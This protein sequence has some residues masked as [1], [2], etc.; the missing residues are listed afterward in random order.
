MKYKEV[1]NIN[2]GDIV[3]QDLNFHDRV[4]L[5]DGVVITE[6]LLDLLKKKGI[7]GLFIVEQNCSD[8][9]T[10]LDNE[11]TK[12]LKKFFFTSLVEVGSEARYGFALH[13][14]C[15]LNDVEEKFI[16]ILSDEKVYDLIRRLDAHDHGTYLHSFDV[17]VLSAVITRDI[18]LE[19]QMDFLTG[20]LLHDIG[21][22]ETPLSILNKPAK[23]SESEYIQIRNHTK[24]GYKLIQRLS[25]SRLVAQLSKSHHE[26]LD[27][28]GY[29][30]KLTDIRLS[31]ELKILMI[32]DVY[33][34][35]TLN[36][37]Y[38]KAY[39]S[40]KAIDILLK[41]RNKFKTKY[42][43]D[44]MDMLK[45][46]PENSYVYLS[47][48]NI[49]RIIDHRSIPYLP[50]IQINDDLEVRQMPTDLSIRAKSFIQWD[51]LKAN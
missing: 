4:L 12:Q 36:R 5:E 40:S 29:P 18:P 9:L 41:E 45:I 31:E 3:A 30:E 27:G 16:R 46:Y 23:L 20:C 24:D 21:K 33:S 34:A 37:S 6:K 48:G 32:V 26:R 42:I 44:L 49:A 7:K 1:I 19:N 14:L 47:N 38:R 43:I 17:F 28:T 39:S 11:K 10:L 51:D 50:I 22:L 35:L 8:N 2:V 15:T 13:D 25:F